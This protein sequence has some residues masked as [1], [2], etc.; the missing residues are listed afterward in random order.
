M[1]RRKD[2]DDY[3]GPPV[4]IFALAPHQAVMQTGYGPLVRPSGHGGLT[5]LTSPDGRPVIRTAHRDLKPNEV[6]FILR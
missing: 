2:D 4:R 3:S 6:N 1:P 5:L